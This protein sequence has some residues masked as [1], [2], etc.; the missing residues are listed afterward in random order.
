MTRN[1]YLSPRY[2]RSKICLDVPGDKKYIGRNAALLGD[3]KSLEEK[4]F[5]AD[6]AQDRIAIF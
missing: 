4:F 2:T 1:L 3:E 6:V 5:F